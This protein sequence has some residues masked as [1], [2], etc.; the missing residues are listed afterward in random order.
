LQ[1]DTVRASAPMDTADAEE[2]DDYWADDALD[3][4]FKKFVDTLK[5]KYNGLQRDA[6]VVE[7][8]RLK[9]FLVSTRT[10][11]GQGSSLVERCVTAIR[12]FEAEFGFID[13]VPYLAGVGRRDG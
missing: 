10:A 13:E 5:H 7:H 3:G 4:D 11:H 12:G 6:I 9:R 8:E 1:C 2:L